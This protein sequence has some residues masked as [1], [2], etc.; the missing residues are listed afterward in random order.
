[1]F[2]QEPGVTMIELINVSKSYKLKGVRKTIL[3]DLSFKFPHKR[4]VAIMGNNG[5]GKST[6]MRLIAG[7][8]LPDSGRIYRSAMVSW[9]LG[10]AGGFNGSMTGLENVRF[11]ARIYGRDTEAVIDYVEEFAELGPSLKLPIKTYSS[12][13]RARLAFGLSMAIDF[14]YYLIDE[15]TAVGDEN[16]KRKS[17]QA[18]KE[19]LSESQIIMISHSASAIKTYCDCGLILAKGGAFYY[20]EIDQLI[21]AYKMSTW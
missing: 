5:A 3:E 8:E 1:M 13:M 14:D 20:E 15:I 10:F 9:P 18:F 19:K 12:G 16:F 7:T 11:V 2:P 4:N 21:E 6:L 17:Q